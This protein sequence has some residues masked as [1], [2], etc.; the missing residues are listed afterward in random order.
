LRFIRELR[1]SV[2]LRITS[3]AL[4]VV[5][6]ALLVCGV[7]L[8][9]GLHTALTREVR[10]T[11]TVLAG[12]VAR[13]VESGGDARELVVGDDD[14]ALAVLGPD[15]EVLTAT[16]NTDGGGLLPRLA[17]G[18]SRVIDVPF[19]DEP[20]IVVA[21]AADGGRTV[22]LA[23][24]LD[25]VEEST[26]TLAA[27]LVIG[28]P[29]LLVVIAATT[30]RMV[31]RALA[32]V[33]AMRAEVDAISAADPGHRL[34]RPVADDE[35]G[36]LADTMNRMLD[37]LDRARARERQFVADASHELRSPIAAIRQHAE[38]ALGHPELTSELARVTHT[39]SL[40]MQALIDDLMLLARADARTLA[41]R[42]QPVDLDDVVL[43]EVT[44]LRAADGVTVDTR[45]VSA[46]RADA[47]PTALGRV[48]SNLGD[49]AV[50]HAE[51]RVAFGLSAVDGWAVL[52]VDD[53]GA[54]VPAA[55]RSRVFERFVR[56]DDA[57]GRADGGSGLG[58][59]IVAEVVAAHGG[60]VS[61]GT[62]PLGGARVTV[63]LPL[64]AG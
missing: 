64:R 21:V 14:V 47:D 19:D 10:A 30:W 15:G 40:R 48:L 58:L 12:E 17:P 4:G 1:G 50:R 5:A 18:E 44:R 45:D 41:V 20:F 29:A 7:A 38:V 56:L 23:R 61:I 46:V 51:G 3:A 22:L 16:A 28:L 6:A 54:G 59:A 37:R 31:G 57:R 25:T 55:D 42:R 36:R 13:S 62:S 32:P 52:C 35:I 9:W 24:S 34:R 26:R 43:A 2:R 53:D 63:R 33:D 11:A 8:V 60:A 49:N 39:E 27:L